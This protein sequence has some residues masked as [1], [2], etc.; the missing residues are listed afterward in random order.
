MDRGACRLSEEDARDDL[1][2]EAAEDDEGE[3]TCVCASGACPS[4]AQFDP[5]RSNPARCVSHSS[6][7]SL[8]LHSIVLYC[9]VFACES[10]II[11]II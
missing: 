2:H 10:S 11:S 3:D 5:I 4:V 8:S 9:I 1:E 7:S 6:Y